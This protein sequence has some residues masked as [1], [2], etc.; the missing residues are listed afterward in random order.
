V[1]NKPFSKVIKTTTTHKLERLIGK[2]ELQKLRLDQ[3]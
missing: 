3:P 1:D 2:G